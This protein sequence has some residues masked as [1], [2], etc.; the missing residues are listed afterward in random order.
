MPNRKQPIRMSADRAEGL[1]KSKTSAGKPKPGSTS[2]SATITR[3]MQNK[4]VKDG[5]V[6]LGRGGKSYNVYDAN[7]GTWKR[8]VVTGSGATKKKPER[9]VYGGT[10]KPTGREGSN[11]TGPATFGI[12]NPKDGGLYRFGGPRSMETYRWSAKSKRFIK[13]SGK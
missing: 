10:R 6:R 8:G 13:T 2:K 11:N 9:A 5:T 4:G 1:R 7:S 12:K 3:Q